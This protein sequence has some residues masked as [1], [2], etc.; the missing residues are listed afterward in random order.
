MN[1]VLDNK[2]V[3]KLVNFNLNIYNNIEGIIELLFASICCVDV[4]DV[5]VEGN[6]NN[7]NL[8]LFCNGKMEEYCLKLEYRDELLSDYDFI[9]FVDGSSARKYK[10]IYD[11][12]LKKYCLLLHQF[13]LKK[14]DNLIIEVVFYKYG[15]HVNIYNSSKIFSY[16]IYGNN[17][18]FDFEKFNQI[19]PT[20]IEFD[21][22]V[23]LDKLKL[24]LIDN[25]F[26]RILMHEYCG[27]YF[28]NEILELNSSNVRKRSL[29]FSMRKC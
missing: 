29:D 24:C 22:S 17:V 19:L 14:N 5:F 2:A 1:V 27:Y 3:E 21:D 25:S 8:K 20:D 23:V 7:N 9:S 26:D 11:G 15:V 12:K 10:F 4:N 28:D 6:N 16:D 18:I 13:D